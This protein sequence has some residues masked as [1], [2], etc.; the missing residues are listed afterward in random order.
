[1]KTLNEWMDANEISAEKAAEIF[2]KSE[3]TIRNWR[4][5]GVPANQCKWVEKRMTE[6]SGKPLPTLP[7][8][9][10][11]EIT[12]EQ[13]DL[14]NRAA[15]ASRQIVREWAADV[16]DYHALKETAAA[17]PKDRPVRYTDLPQQPTSR[18]NDSPEPPDPPKP[19]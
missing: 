3:G 8:R 7:D 9:I 5:Q 11:L 19:R 12:A 16:L 1:M 15:L 17:T 6:W 13:F 10:T 4:S 2:G 14:W 18:L